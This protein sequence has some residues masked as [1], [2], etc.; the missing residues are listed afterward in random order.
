M[1][2]DA[3]AAAL[4]VAQAN[5]QRLHL[6]VQFVQT[7][8]LNGLAGPFD[9]IV[10]NPPYIADQDQH[11]T[12]LTHEPLTA[13]ASGSDGLNDIRSIVAQSTSRLKPGGW[14]LLEHGYDQAATVRALL[15]AAGL[16]HVQSRQDLAGIERCSGG[17]WSA[18]FASPL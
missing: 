18:A 4:A 16:A 10:S 6:D 12:A 9:L 5:A 11:L 13:L 2:V 8:W 3:S 17:Q 7:S 15:H 14:L 1:A